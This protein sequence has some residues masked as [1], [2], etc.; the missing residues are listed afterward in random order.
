M[1]NLVCK[2]LDSNGKINKNIVAI[3]GGV[4]YERRH[5][6]EIRRIYDVDG[7][8]RSAGNSKTPERTASEVRLKVNASNIKTI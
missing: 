4:K 5:K 8:A 7:S 2:Q 6:N 3:V 1:Q